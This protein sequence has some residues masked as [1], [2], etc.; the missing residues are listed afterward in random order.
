MLTACPRLPL[1]QTGE[2]VSMIRNQIDFIS[3]RNTGLISFIPDISLS[4]KQA[5]MLF[6]EKINIR[7]SIIRPTTNVIRLKYSQNNLTV[8]FNTINYTD[9]EENRFAWR[10]M[11][12]N[13]TSWTELINQNS[14]M[15]YEPAVW[16]EFH[17][18]NALFR[19]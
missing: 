3:E 12:E 4:R 6:I 15:L 10:S 9:P 11:H 5:P 17:T 16:M 18:N 7:D 19:E 13:D 1:L 8:D 2:A 14:I